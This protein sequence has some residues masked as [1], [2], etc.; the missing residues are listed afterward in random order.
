M[1]NFLYNNPFKPTCFVF[2]C[3]KR[4]QKVDK[5]FRLNPVTF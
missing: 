4:I 5:S 2:E 3:D 1:I